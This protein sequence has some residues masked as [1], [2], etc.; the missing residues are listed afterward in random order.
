V[1]VVI[2]GAKQVV[3]RLTDDLSE[4]SLLDQDILEVQMP[5][6]LTIDVGWFPEYDANGAF[7]IRV[8]RDYM[9]NH[10]AGP[11]QSRDA[12]EALRIVKRLAAAC[13]VLAD[14]R[15]P[16]DDPRLDVEPRRI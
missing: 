15:S 7:E 10:V 16:K 13:L 6:G 1:E 8:Y 9:G 2:P 12:H 5:D 11:W 3:G 14:P 4:T